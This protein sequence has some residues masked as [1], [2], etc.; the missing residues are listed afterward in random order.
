MFPC[1]SWDDWWLKLVKS[2]IYL[3]W[4]SLSCYTH[5]ASFCLLAVVPAPR[6]GLS[7]LD[8]AQ[9]HKGTP[10]ERQQTPR[11][12]VALFWYSAET[13]SRMS[14]EDLF[15]GK[16]FLLL[17]DAWISDCVIQ[18]AALEW[19]TSLGV[20]TEAPCESGAWQA[21]QT[22]SVIAGWLV[23]GL[24]RCHR[25]GWLFDRA[26]RPV[27]R[28]TCLGKPEN[29]VYA[30]YLTHSQAVSFSLTQTHTSIEL[31]KPVTLC[32]M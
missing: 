1:S 30:F 2:G 27:R 24:L 4:P 11:E 32:L 19:S 23:M 17:T 21:W 20:Q 26:I 10:A 6:L 7:Q 28:S 18:T 12:T 15:E 3:Q 31:K 8:V 29:C 14:G 9:L 22:Q 5:S 16:L 13:D 25:D